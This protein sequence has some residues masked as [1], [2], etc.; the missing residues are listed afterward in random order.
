MDILNKN[1]LELRFEE[2]V[3]KIKGGAVFIHPSDTIYGLGCNALDEKAVT[4]IRKMKDRPDTP[5][6]IWVP[7]LDWVSKNCTLNDEAKQALSHL[8]GAYTIILPLKE[9]K[10]VAKLVHPKNDSIGIRFPDHWFG[11][12]VEKLGFPI[13][14]TSV[15]KVGQSFMTSLANLD[16]DIQVGVDFAIYEGAKEAH[17]SK[18]VDTTT[19]KV[20]ER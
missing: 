16:S 20:K 1:E 18:I 8:P 10:A 3:K 12:I 2:I 4:K 13:V 7:S 11:K 14:T 6:S 15:N 19:G 5:F 17:P 9:T